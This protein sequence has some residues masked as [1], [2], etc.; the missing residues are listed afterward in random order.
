MTVSLLFGYKGIT[1]FVENGR[2]RPKKRENDGRRRTKTPTT[3]GFA[4]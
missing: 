2:F 3:V 1:I 4:Q